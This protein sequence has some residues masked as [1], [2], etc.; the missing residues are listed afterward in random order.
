[1][2]PAGKGHL[3][4]PASPSHLPCMK[5]SPGCERRLLFCLPGN[6]YDHMTQVCPTGYLRSCQKGPLRQVRLC[7]PLSMVACRE[8][9]REA[10]SSVSDPC[11]LAHSL[12][13]PLSLPPICFCHWPPGVLCWTKPTLEL[14]SSSAQLSHRVFCRI[15][16]EL[17]SG[18]CCLPHAGCV[19]FRTT[20]G[21]L[22]S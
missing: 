7:R 4:S 14:A 10:C 5:P 21:D 16:C 20:P 22:R 19:G 11:P 2:A 18:P 13:R 3:S 9:C 12:P 1:M 17:Q 8:A 15:H 6:W